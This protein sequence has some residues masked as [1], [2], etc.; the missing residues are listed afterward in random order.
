MKLKPAI[1]VCLSSLMC[2]GAAAAGA[3]TGT[4]RATIPWEGKGRVYRIGPETVLF[5]GAMKGIVYA[6][7]DDGILNEGFMVCPLTQRINLTAGA[8]SAVG[9]CEILVEGDHVIYA[10]FVCE[11][12]LGRC[13]GEF[14]LTDGGGRFKG[15]SGSSKLTVRAPLHVI[16]V[17]VASGSEV[18]VATGLAELPELK[19]RIPE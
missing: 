15:I 18:R 6:E 2:L 10:E 1:L 3:E 14:R 11:G 7:R 5:L 8:S 17:D 12:P 9:Q 19:F 13:E 16:A 4:E